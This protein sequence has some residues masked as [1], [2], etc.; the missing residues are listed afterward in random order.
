M[1][2]HPVALQSASLKS[3]GSW[4]EVTSDPQLTGSAPQ[5]HVG[6]TVQLS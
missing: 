5:E 3:P 1:A 6:K 4:E 2:T